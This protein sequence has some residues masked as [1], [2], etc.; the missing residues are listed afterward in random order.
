MTVT[1]DSLDSAV[2]GI[3]RIDGDAYDLAVD[4]NSTDGPLTVRQLA[5]FL[6]TFTYITNADGA[7]PE[8]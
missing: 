2:T 8:A 5:R 6:G 4:F 7:Y 3:E 1:A